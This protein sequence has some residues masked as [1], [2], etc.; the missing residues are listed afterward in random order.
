[1]SSV[2]LSGG[3]ARWIQ[4]LHL[5]G[6]LL[7]LSE[8][9][10]GTL[11]VDNLGVS[12]RALVREVV[13]RLFGGELILWLAGEPAE[14]EPQAD[15]LATVSDAGADG[16]FCAPWGRDGLAVYGQDGR[17]PPTA[18]MRQA[19]KDRRIW[20]ATADEISGP[21]STAGL[22]PPQA[23]AAPILGQDFDRLMVENG[24]GQQVFGVIQIA[25][26]EGPPFTA[27]E[28]ELFHGL[29]AQL[30][31]ALQGHRRVAI[32]RWRMEQ[33][34]LV[35][36]VSARIAEIRS[37]EDLA[38]QVTSLILDTFDYYYVAVFTLEEGEN[39]LRFWASA[40]PRRREPPLDHPPDGGQGGESPE[41]SVQM[42]QGLIG[43]VAETGSEI[44]A[45]DVSFEPRFRY[46]DALPETRSE[47]VLPLKVE[48]RLLGVLDVQSDQP[49]DFTETDML[50]LRA[51][52]DSIALAIE[53]ARLYSA[54][55]RRA[56]QLT[57]VAEVSQ[58]ITS[59]LDEGRLLNE[60]VSLLQKR[61]GYSYV[62][63]FSVHPGR[64]K[65][66]Y[67]AGSDPRSQLLRAEQFAY[68]LDDPSGIIPWVARNG[69]TILAN[70]VSQ[71][72]RY[73]PSSLP[74]DNT[75]SELCVPLIYGGETLGVLDAQSDR[76]NAFNEDDRFLFEA[77]ADNV[78]VAVRNATLYRSERWRRQVADSLREVA[79][80]LSA[81][82]G[83]DQVLDAVMAEL[84]RNLPI[85]A[86]AIWLLDADLE[87]GGTPAL[88]LAS[89][90]GALEKAL[91]VDSASLVDW[92]EAYD[93]PEEQGQEEDPFAWLRQALE[94]DEPLVREPGAPFEPLG[95][96]LDF[97][98][99]YSAIAA[100]LRVGAQRLGILTLAHRSAKRYGSESHAMAAAFASY[101]SV[102]IQN[103]RLYEAAHEQAW[104]ATVLLQVAEATRSLTSLIDVLATVARITPLL[105]GVKASV[106]YL[107]DSLSESFIPAA[108][109][110]L[111]T[112]GRLEFERWRIAAGDA[113][114]FDRV[115]DLQET[116]VV[117]D[118]TAHVD[119][120]DLTFLGEEKEAE[121]PDALVERR[122][123]IV[124][125]LASH[126]EFLGVLVVDYSDTEKAGSNPQAIF[127]ERLAILEGIAHQ[128]AVAIE[129]RRL[130][131]AQKEE[132]YV[133]V[134]LLQVAQAVVSLN[135]LNDIL[136][137][138]VRITPIL[139]GVRRS[140]LYLWD[141]KG[142]SFH[143][144]QS[145]G[146]GRQADDR[147]YSSG[148]FPLLDA[149]LQRDHLVAMPLDDQL[150]SLPAA[151]L[152]PPDNWAQIQAPTPE[153][154]EVYLECEA[155]L[156]FAFPL[157]ARGEVLGVLLVEEPDPLFAG[158]VAV[159]RNLQRLREKR[160]EIV[161]GISQQV[162]L[163][164]QND[165]L[166]Q[167]TVERE[168][169]AREFQL[170]REIQ[171]TF[172][173]QT[174]P[175]PPGWD[176]GVRWRAAYEVSGDFYDLFELPGGRLG[177]V[178]A[179]VAD[180]GMPAA[181]FMTLT[182]TL[183]RASVQSETPDLNHS[184]VS[185]AQVL[186]R[187]NDVMLVDAPKEMFVT[188]FYG[189]LD[190][191]TGQLTYANAGHNPPLCFPG[192]TRKPRRLER[193]GMALGVL[194]DSRI[195][196]RQITLQ[197]GDLLVFYTDGI[198]EAF[199]PD[200]EM[201]GEA[202]LIGVLRKAY[203]QPG[204]AVDEILD[205]VESDVCDFLENGLIGDDLTLVAIRRQALDPQ[206]ET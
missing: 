41:I 151:E 35:R 192:E 155:P 124:I 37:L 123:F 206:A 116:V 95:A 204:I 149:A 15:R 170:A 181:L 201:Y 132:A 176:L 70:D 30:A 105:V 13:E 93:R 68:D 46:S 103:A 58:A 148:E 83:L 200:Q 28:L 100:P 67:E 23:A 183:L 29:A 144:A 163:A 173:P 188:L 34:E 20:C 51:L 84:E 158:G 91:P 147:H 85:D 128:T 118:L 167:E 43:Q 121:R 156:V 14:V 74:P 22:E 150:D 196:E 160:V 26:P 127:G 154:V 197:P 157:T 203:N 161:T 99:D 104:M 184:V 172:L 182:R 122:W 65:V 94:A 11:E 69:A 136:G 174:L 81:D 75:R 45:C 112:T 1:M 106:L 17:Q 194:E 202:R 97:P 109:S 187:I 168:R 8:Q 205:R 55:R 53:D 110:G 66:F 193:T 130:F 2:P 117:S 152:E 5:G 129:N 89:V 52:A 177:I 72:P 71:E 73:R 185:P 133:S 49:D 153:E 60:V 50:V 115:H 77:L 166:Q 21:C 169:L 113:P 78:A 142:R 62:H 54:L 39:H 108:A 143:L 56:T 36:Q 139:V 19:A 63:L 10:Q 76:V 120:P 171:Q 137:A 145:Y 111:S 18:L 125:P 180:K 38:W 16:G 195:D 47:V 64:R 140:L 138:V 131:D 114:A 24:D 146:I 198:T 12:H 179:D 59:I 33:L 40:G 79:G 191:E 98:A 6:Q 101:A 175:Y 57:T 119:L 92:R 87:D 135:E 178:V 90:H 189:V 42:G 48:D 44:V 32:E 9:A 4:I 107:W 165:R 61:F 86:A 141:S 102:A 159:E 80:L 96:A 3:S 31:L 82:V 164:I 190:L 7:E 134:A 186:G 88:R 162:A 27:E 25:R 126:D 199:S